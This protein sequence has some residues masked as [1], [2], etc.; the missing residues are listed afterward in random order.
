MVGG[1]RRLGSPA[2]RDCGCH[3]VEWP[4]LDGP[5]KALARRRNGSVKSC[6]TSGASQRGRL[7]TDRR[8]AGRR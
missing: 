3:D 7:E 5:A 2:G 6:L 4:R 8:G 1:M